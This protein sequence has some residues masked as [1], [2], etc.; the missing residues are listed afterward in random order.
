MI[1]LS[2]IP[3]CYV[4]TKV[5]E[6]VGQ[7]ARKYNHQ[8]GCGDVA[9]VLKTKF[10]DTT[11]IGIIDEDKNKGPA[12]KY[13]SEF[14]EVVQ[15][16]ELILR[17]HKSKPQ[18]LIVVCPEIEKWLVNEANGVGIALSGYNL[19]DNLKGFKELTK[20]QNI[21][22]NIDFYRFIKALI[23]KEAVGIITLRKWIELYKE[24]KLD[25]LINS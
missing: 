4:D 8:H 9:R 19:P 21:D 3:E 10:S 6:I 7:A 16:N 14:A 18:Y 13:F 23:R 1:E 20:T 5:A 22:R 2:I 11:A 12:A 24:N 25:S 15:Q 17:K